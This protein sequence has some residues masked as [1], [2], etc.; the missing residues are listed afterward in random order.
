MTIQPDQTGARGHA[1]SSEDSDTA[2]ALAVSDA[3]SRDR[4]V[5]LV[6]LSRV[7]RWLTDAAEQ[8]HET[9]AEQI[10]DRIDARIE[11]LS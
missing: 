7:R 3:L 2:Q 1:A 5:A 9:V 10:I 8:S 4:R 6:E 11:L